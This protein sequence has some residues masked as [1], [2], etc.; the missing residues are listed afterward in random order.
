M[1][2]GALDVEIVFVDIDGE[3]CGDQWW[4][5]AQNMAGMPFTS[6]QVGP[7][8]AGAIAVAIWLFEGGQIGM[9]N[10]K[11]FFYLLAY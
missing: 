4:E 2:H 11:H 8:G 1:N 10:K 9:F 5:R 6:I 7:I 3:E